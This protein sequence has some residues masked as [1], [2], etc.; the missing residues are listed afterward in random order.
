MG[1]GRNVFECLTN[2]EKNQHEG[3]DFPMSL[4]SCRSMSY[5]KSKHERIQF[6]NK[7]KQSEDQFFISRLNIFRRY[8]D[9]GDPLALYHLKCSAQVSN[10][11]E[12][13]LRLLVDLAA[14][15]AGAFL[16]LFTK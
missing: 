10:A 1:N 9:Q 14:T 8:V 5:I 6:Q 2:L 4:D 16:N 11:M 3:I 12:L 7:P 13:H 15:L